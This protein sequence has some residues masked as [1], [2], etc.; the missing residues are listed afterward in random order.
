ML[1]YTLRPKTMLRNAKTNVLVVL[2]LA[3]T[4]VARPWF[5]GE[6]VHA[7]RFLLIH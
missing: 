3:C 1:S 2:S 7:E 5:Q 6:G 4:L